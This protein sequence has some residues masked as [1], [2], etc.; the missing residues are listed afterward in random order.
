[1]P[2]SVQNILDIREIQLCRLLDKAS[3]FKTPPKQS[4]GVSHAIHCIR[5]V[6]NR[7]TEFN[8]KS[9]SNKQT[10]KISTCEGLM[11]EAV[12]RYVQRY[13]LTDKPLASTTLWDAPW[14]QLRHASH[15]SIIKIIR[16]L[17][18]SKS[19]WL[20]LFYNPIKLFRVQ[21]QFWICNSR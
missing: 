8:N 4:K 14:I 7:T 15:Y 2:G 18:N 16:Q 3:S 11:I 6:E 9:N 12:N 20:Y 1:M 19:I 13:R 5:N 17:E 21:W 10:Q